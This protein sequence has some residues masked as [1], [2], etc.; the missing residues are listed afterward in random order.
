[1]LFKSPATVAP[2]DPRSNPIHL[3]NFPMI[4]LDTASRS[5]AVDGIVL[6]LITR[7]VQIAWVSGSVA[8]YKTRR[9]DQLRFLASYIFKP[10]ELS[11]GLFANWAKEE[12]AIYGIASL[13]N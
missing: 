8:T 4:T 2:P 12:E 5:S 3:T 10:A 6:P 11:C 13:G 9:R 1:M 7:N